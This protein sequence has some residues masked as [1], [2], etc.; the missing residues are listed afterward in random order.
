MVTKLPSRSVT[1][2][3]ELIPIGAIVAY[4]GST[5]PTTGTLQSSM[6]FTFGDTE[7]DDVNN[8]TLA[9]ISTDG[10]ARTYTIRN[11]YGASTNIQFNAAADIGACVANLKAAIEHADGHAGKLV[12]SADGGAVTITQAVAGSGG[13]T[14]ITSAANFD[15]ACDVNPPAAFTSGTSD[16]WL[17][18]DGTAI[19][20]T[21]YAA[22]FAQISTLYGTGDGSTTFNL[23]DCRGRF[24]VGRD[25]MGPT[26]AADRITSAEEG[27]DAGTIGATGATVVDTGVNSEHAITVNWAIRASSSDV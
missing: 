6:T 11:D 14:I 7:F 10:T 25:D 27:I 9:L 5:P 26:A 16:G 4:L 18:C 22:L 24:L 23:P 8:G 20:R 1:F 2:P 13:N 12:V 19:S 21:T 17:F 15:N 3:G